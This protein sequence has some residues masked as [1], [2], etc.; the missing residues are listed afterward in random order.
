LGFRQLDVAGRDVVRHN[1]AGDEVG[2]VRLSELG[3][4]RDVPADHQTNL[5]LVVKELDVP[6]FDDLV[7]GPADRTRCLAKEGERDGIWVHAG[8]L[9][10]RNIVRHLRHHTARGGHRRD[11]VE[12]VDRHGVGAVCGGVDGRPV[13][14]QLTGGGG[15]S[16]DFSCAG[17]SLDPPRVVGSKD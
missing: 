10:V 7:E 8:A 13:G 12:A 2:Q 16:G 6:G 3:A 11:E 5:D 9:D 14:Q 4:E 1:Q 15:E 17:G